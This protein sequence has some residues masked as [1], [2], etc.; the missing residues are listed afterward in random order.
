[1]RKGSGMGRL[2]QGR[3][4]LAPE[5]ETSIAFKAER[6]KVYTGQGKIIGQ[7]LI[8]GE[9]VKGEASSELAEII[10]AEERNATDAINRDRIPRQYQRSVKEYFSRV[11][12]LLG[13]GSTTTDDESET[14]G[15]SDRDTAD[16][17]DS[18]P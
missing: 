3:G 16:D 8:E 1:M 14:D 13:G 12:K 5:E 17:G 18:G 7:F 4:G 15:E 11:Q 6:S 9:Q 10:S 2:G